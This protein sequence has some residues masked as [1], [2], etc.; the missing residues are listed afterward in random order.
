M[1]SQNAVSEAPKEAE[2]STSGVSH[3]S[4]CRVL[5]AMNGMCEGVNEAQEAVH[6]TTTQT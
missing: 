6:F 4:W 3:P 5:G 2:L 1:T